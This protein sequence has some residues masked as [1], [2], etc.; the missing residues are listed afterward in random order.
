MIETLKMLAW[1]EIHGFASPG[2]YQRFV[3][4]IEEQ[5]ATGHAKELPTDPQYA[6]G[7]IRG[8]RWFRDNGSG[9]VWRLIAPDS[10]FRGL[11]EPVVQSLHT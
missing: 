3:Q 6:K 9:A 2:E 4:Y 1:E 7:M 8:G 10:P 11:W 5:V